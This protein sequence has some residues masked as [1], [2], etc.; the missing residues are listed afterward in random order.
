MTDSLE[1]LIRAIGTQARAAS[2]PM[3]R[4]ETAAK[5]QALRAIAERLG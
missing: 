2:R 1:S 3:S 5:N 4:A